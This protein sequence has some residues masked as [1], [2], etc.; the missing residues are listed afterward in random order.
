MILSDVADRGLLHVVPWVG[1]H[2]ATASAPCPPWFRAGEQDGLADPHGMSFVAA[3][4]WARAA[5]PLALL[6]ECVDGLPDHPHFP[7]ILA[8]IQWAGYRVHHALVHDQAAL[9]PPLVTPFLYHDFQVQEAPKFLQ[10][11]PTLPGADP[12]LRT[13]QEV[14]QRRVAPTDQHLRTLCARYSQQHALLWLTGGFLPSSPLL[15]VARPSSPPPS[16]FSS[17]LGAGLPRLGQLHLYPAGCHFVD[18]AVAS[19]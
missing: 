2:V 17:Y 11:T 13:A 18:C 3:L 7:V 14:L 8:T 4:A 6:M 10:H 9:L 19:Y 1:T 5:A 12:P 16:G 15:M